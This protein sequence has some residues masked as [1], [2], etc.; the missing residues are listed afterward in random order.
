VERCVD[1][2]WCVDTVRRCVADGT[3]G[4]RCRVSAMP[5]DAGLGCGV[6]GN[7]IAS[8]ALGAACDPGRV[9]NA[10]VA[11]QTCRPTG[12]SK[13][14]TCALPSYVESEIVSPTFIEACTADAT[15]PAFGSL[16]DAVSPSLPLGFTL[17]AYGAGYTSMQVSTN[18]VVRLGDATTPA[19]PLSGLALFP[20]SAATGAV[21]A[22]FWTDLVLRTERSVCVRTTGVA[23][24]RVTVVEWSDVTTFDTRETN[25]TF[26]VVM[27]EGSNQIDLVYQTL[28]RGTGL[29]YLA[30]GTNAAIGVQG[31]AGLDFNRHPGAVSTTRG[32]R[33]TPR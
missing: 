30:D 4:G 27:R 2:A 29:A 33:F 5:C 21:I 11:P 23:P 26:E 17:R 20:W 22:A 7:C 16:D 12:A 10:C 15:R 25:L 6:A 32:V 1:G 9:S 24:T 31:S 8:V 13:T 19:L 3:A 28:D 14:S 18:G